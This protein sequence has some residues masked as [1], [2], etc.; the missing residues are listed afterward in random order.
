[1]SLFFFLF[2]IQ[3]YHLDNTR[4]A[5]SRGSAYDLAFVIKTNLELY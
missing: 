4:Q 1:L 5:T 3:Y 2:G